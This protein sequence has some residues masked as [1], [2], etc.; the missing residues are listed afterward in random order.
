MLIQLQKRFKLLCA[1]SAAIACQAAWADTPIASASASFSNL[2]FRLIDLD[3]ND[4]ITPGMVL[5]GGG[6]VGASTSLG[7]NDPSPVMETVTLTGL[8]FSP[9][10]ISVGV[11]PG[12]GTLDADGMSGNS[13]STV[14]NALLYAQ[15]QQ[16]DDGMVKTHQKYTSGETISGASF[17]N[18]PAV[19]GFSSDALT[20]TLTANTGLVIE[21]TATASMWLSQDHMFQTLDTLAGQITGFSPTVHPYA[22]AFGAAQVDLLAALVT[23]SATGV[24]DGELVLSKFS[25]REGI[26]GGAQICVSCPDDIWTEQSR[27]LSQ[28]ISI[29][30]TNH[31]GGSVDVSFVLHAMASVTNTAQVSYYEVLDPPTVPV[32]PEPGTCALMGLGL[33]GLA[34][35]R[36]RHARR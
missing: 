21:G 20:I 6:F 16:Q 32:I 27:T 17:G 7:S 18:H 22:T 4:G 13:R 15:D 26:E 23:G 31:S 33:A 29:D 19:A 36:R 9:Q 2:S 34:W 1:A 8:P 35:A 10:T 11:G 14:E 24:A 25:F 28:N 5:Q 30:Y 3:L 12:T